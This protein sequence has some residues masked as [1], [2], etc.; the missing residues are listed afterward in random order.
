MSSIIGV[1]TFYMNIYVLVLVTKVEYKHIYGTI[2]VGNSDSD[3]ILCARDATVLQHL[4]QGLLLQASYYIE[5]WV[6]FITADR[7]NIMT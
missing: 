2:V 1:N 4:P 5:A 6:A 3:A 7:A